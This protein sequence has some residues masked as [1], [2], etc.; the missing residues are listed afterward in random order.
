MSV[1]FL[2]YGEDII[3]NSKETNMM[4]NHSGHMAERTF[5]RIDKKYAIFFDLSDTKQIKKWILTKMAG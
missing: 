4:A 5:L 2:V 1:A 3:K